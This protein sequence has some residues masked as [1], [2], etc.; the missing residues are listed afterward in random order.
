MADAENSKISS[1]EIPSGQVEAELKNQEAQLRARYGNI[2]KRKG[3]PMLMKKLAGKK[4]YFDSGDYNMQNS[5]QKGPLVPNPMATKNPI[6]LSAP[7][8]LP[9]AVI[10]RRASEVTPTPNLQQR[11]GSQSTLAQVSN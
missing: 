9:P 8:Q 7:N 1:E 11:R 4:Q 6:P 2:D 10:E 5:K 3:N